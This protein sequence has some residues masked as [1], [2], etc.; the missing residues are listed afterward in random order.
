MSG[1]TETPLHSVSIQDRICT[2]AKIMNCM[3][4]IR[5]TIY[6]YAC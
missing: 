6:P 5:I 3:I 4:L 2:E 1:T